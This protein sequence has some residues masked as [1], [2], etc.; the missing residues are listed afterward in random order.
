MSTK[1]RSP[2]SDSESEFTTMM[3]VCTMFELQSR[4]AQ[5]KL[6]R[7]EMKLPCDI[8]N[9]LSSFVLGTIASATVGPHVDILLSL[10]F[11]GPRFSLRF[12]KHD[13]CHS[14]LTNAIEYF[15]R[16]KLATIDAMIDFM[17]FLARLTSHWST[18]DVE[19][20]CDSLCEIGRYM[21]KTMVVCNHT[22]ETG[23]LKSTKPDVNLIFDISLIQ[24]KEKENHSPSSD[25]KVTHVP[26]KRK[27]SIHAF[28]GR[29]I[30]TESSQ[31]DIG[32]VLSVDP[33][34]AGETLKEYQERIFKDG[35]HIPRIMCFFLL[36]IFV[37]K[38]LPDFLWPYHF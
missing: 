7:G 37:N 28:D 34:K 24:S 20:Y 12:M 27:S 6:N 31:V 11:S 26:D 3:T 29:N 23:D 17:A 13:L 1:T 25:S 4:R 10:T 16:N 5:R 19:L 14:S 36:I 38:E 32:I 30:G 8:D 21:A 35:R 33:R 15:S 18:H 22:D 2:P 9:R